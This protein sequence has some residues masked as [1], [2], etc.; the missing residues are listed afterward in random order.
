MRAL[1]VAVDTKSSCPAFWEREEPH[2]Q[3]LLARRPYVIF[4]SPAGNAYSLRASV[5]ERVLLE[6]GRTGDQHVRKWSD[7]TC[8][9]P[10]VVTTVSRARRGAAGG[11]SC[12]SL[13]TVRA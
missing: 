12:P 5:A 10:A 3:R 2:T 1:S 13:W 8:W 9:A 6:C 11:E 7:S 4:F